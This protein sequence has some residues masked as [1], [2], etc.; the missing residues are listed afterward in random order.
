MLNVFGNVSGHNCDGS[1][2]R[3]V[4]RV[5][6]LGIAGL[7]LPNLLRAR[8]QAASVGNSSKQTSVVL[9]WLPGGPTHMDTYDLK[10]DAPAE[11]R[12]SFKPIS[13]R[14]PGMEIS[15]L[16]PKQA[17][18]TDKLA[19]VRSFT[20]TNAG[21]GGGTH[22]V[23]TGFDHPPA[24]SGEPQIYPSP[25]SVVARVRGNHPVTGMPPYVALNRIYGDGPAYLGVSSAP[26][27]SGGPA[28]QNMTLAGGVDLTRLGDRRAL[29]KGFDSLRR[30][31]DSS[32]TMGGLDSFELQAFNLILGR[33]ARQAF[34]L[35][36]EDPKVRTLYGDGL[37][38]QLLI[39]RRIC[40][41]GASFVS[42]A[43]NGW[44]DH[45]SIEAA[46]RAKLP[47]LDRAVAS[48][49]EDCSQRGLDRNILL[50]ITGEFGRTPRIN[51]SAG[52]DHWPTGMFATLAGG[53]LKMGQ[54][55]GET[56]A[57]GE[58]PK[59][60]PVTPQDLMATIYRVLGVDLEAQ[61]YNSAG[62]P[63]PILTHGKPVAELI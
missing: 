1:T 44:D 10:P 42:I 12:G 39:A 62:R 57:K 5:G 31:V 55:I 23:M 2:R 33:E 6:S 30:D 40:E 15:E 20:H 24:D 59:S 50:V 58:V 29:L 36:S 54:V 60:R 35:S 26:F 56:N 21:H 34:D 63:T 45:G 48:F 3:D 19:I 43:W 7:T 53:G 4:L 49:V 17:A 61:F 41:A 14:V 16:M 46:M 18:L 28:K 27:E 9:L 52:R 13:G 25:G 11:F 22:W 37:G 51:G 8:A 47:P 38:E 32:G